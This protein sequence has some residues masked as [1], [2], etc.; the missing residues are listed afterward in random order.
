MRPITDKKKE[1]D[2]ACL[3]GDAGPRPEKQRKWNRHA[4][5]SGIGVRENI[6]VEAVYS[7]LSPHLGMG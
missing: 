5:N 1:K 2:G 3:C 7:F 6:M 4:K